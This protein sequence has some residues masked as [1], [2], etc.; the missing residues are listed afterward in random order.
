MNDKKFKTRFTIQFSRY[1][2]LHL[3]VAEILNQQ[4]LR[5]K[6]QY[7]VNAVRHYESHNGTPGFLGID[8]SYIETIV[9]K[10]LLER[11]RKGTG[12]T[13]PVAVP[14]KKEPSL[15]KQESAEVNVFNAV[16]STLE[17]FRNR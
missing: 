4:A 7:I 14:L 15:L 12:V 2:P 8:E 17:M 16:A 11:E 3:Q 1:D 5:G 9:T 10:I 13:L 6:A